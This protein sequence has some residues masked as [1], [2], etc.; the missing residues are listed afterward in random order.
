MKSSINQNLVISGDNT[1]LN[2]L[3]PFNYE[4]INTKEERGRATKG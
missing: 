1:L 3:I 4:M 2:V